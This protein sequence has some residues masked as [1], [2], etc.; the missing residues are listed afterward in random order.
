[1]SE[2][3]EI[4]NATKDIRKQYSAERKERN[5]NGSA[6]MLEQNGISFES[7]N[8]GIHLIVTH[9]GY[10][11]DLWPT[12]GKFIIRGYKKHLRGVRLLIKIVRGD[13]SENDLKSMGIVD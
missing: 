6:A 10:V 8:D 7:K 5:K 1:M 2:I 12:T 4:Y 11:V 9:G 13:Y 3:A